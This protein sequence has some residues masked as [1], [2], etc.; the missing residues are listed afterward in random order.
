MLFHTSLISTKFDQNITTQNITTSDLKLIT[1]LCIQ[2]NNYA[3]YASLYKVLSL[4][5]K[6]KNNLCF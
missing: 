3:F 5:I 1:L 4:N 2:L 6:T